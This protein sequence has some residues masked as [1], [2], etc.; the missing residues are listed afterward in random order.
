MK[1]RRFYRRDRGMTKQ[2]KLQWALVVAV[3]VVVFLVVFVYRFFAHCIFEWPIRWD[4]KT[5]WNEQV[6]PAKEE[7]VEE[8]IKFAP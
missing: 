1:R 6:G 5:C 2:E 7:A 8:S 3:F 4:V